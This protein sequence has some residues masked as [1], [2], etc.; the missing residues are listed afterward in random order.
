MLN[1]G[2]TEGVPE[3]S[4]YRSKATQPECR[5]KSLAPSSSLTPIIYLCTSSDHSLYI[6][7]DPTTDFLPFCE[8]AFLAPHHG[9]ITGLPI[10]FFDQSQPSLLKSS[11]LPCDWSSL[12]LVYPTWRMLVL[13]SFFLLQIQPG[14]QGLS[15]LPPLVVGITQRQNALRTSTNLSFRSVTHFRLRIKI[16]CKQAKI[17][18][19]EV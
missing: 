5:R 11:R 1:S 17:P 8:P 4:E 6:P 16:Q 7:K 14:S 3:T 12:S 18:Y 2:E 13:M 10:V 9:W 15:S 19:R